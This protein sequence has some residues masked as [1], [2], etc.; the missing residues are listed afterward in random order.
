MSI[1][2]EPKR[3]ALGTSWTRICRDIW[4][5]EGTLKKNILSIIAAAMFLIASGCE[6][7]MNQAMSSVAKEA[8]P[9]SL[10]AFGPARIHI[11]AL[12]EI[13]SS[14]VSLNEAKLRVYV[15]L[16]DVYES[17]LKAPGTFRFELYEHVPRSSEPKGTGLIN[18]PP[19]DLNHPETNNDHWRDYLRSYQFDFDID[20]NPANTQAFVIAAIYTTPE[21]KRLT[22]EHILRYRE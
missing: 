4:I 16:L 17:R 13:T 21:G 15:D 1:I 20:I 22:D 7:E 19:I 5:K 14:S 18:W 11:I 9:R 10:R 8:P 12:T 2:C 6:S 3:T